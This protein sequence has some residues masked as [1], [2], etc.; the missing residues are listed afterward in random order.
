MNVSK[1]SK[2]FILFPPQLKLMYEQET[3]SFNRQ[4]YM[5]LFLFYIPVTFFAVIAEIIGLTGPTDSFFNYTHAGY[6]ISAIV[7][8]ALFFAKKI[9]VAGCL[10]MFTAFGQLTISTEMIY[11]SFTP[12]EYNKMLIVANIVLLAMNAM[13]SMTVYLRWNT[14]ILGVITIGTYITCML[15]TGDDAMHSF[16]ILFLI[17]FSM[18]SVFGL[19]VANISYRLEQAYSQLK[20]DNTELLHILRLKKEDVMTYISLA[21]EKHS[22]DGLRVL[23]D[24]L[25][26]KS[27]HNLLTNVELYLKNRDT[28]IKIIEKCFPEL[29]PSEREI[30]RLILQG[31]KLG[32]ICT[33]LD[34]SESNIN[35]QR[36]NMRRKLGLQSSDNLMEQL[37]IRLN[38]FR[39]EKSSF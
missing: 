27:M 38:E 2:L 30:C 24:R 8:I 25:D 36:A 4:R 16:L 6:I 3:S 29:T 9:S 34:K 14:V 18:I 12:T 15:I 39:G 32:E 1:L 35:S 20:K 5:L 7:L 11:V 37:Q 17:T 22:H 10:A 33:I 13:V 23:M 21:S 31:K 19:W 28:D 26:K